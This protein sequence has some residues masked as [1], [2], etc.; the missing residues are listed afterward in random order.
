MIGFEI[1][2]T[3]CDGAQKPSQYFR[4]QNVLVDS[5]GQHLKLA[6]LVLLVFSMLGA[7]FHERQLG[8]RI[9]RIVRISI[10]G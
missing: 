4:P 7:Q 8:S 10:A 3:S 2:V 9:R 6:D 5:T 1:L